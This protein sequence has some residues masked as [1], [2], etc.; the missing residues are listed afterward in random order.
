MSLINTL[1]RTPCGACGCQVGVLNVHEDK[2]ILDEEISVKAVDC[3][4]LGG[5]LGIYGKGS[6]GGQ[7]WRRVEC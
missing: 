3:K 2:D 4:G 5:D 6:A 1:C 7:T